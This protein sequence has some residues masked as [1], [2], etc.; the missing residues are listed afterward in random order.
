MTIIQLLEGVL[1][2]AGVVGT[3][4]ATLKYLIRFQRKIDRLL[5]LMALTRNR[6]ED[7]ENFLEKN[8]EFKQKKRIEND[9][10]PEL[11]TDFV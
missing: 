7:V 3:F 11:N 2:I 1:I 10:L 9:E 5:I 4:L 8:T 6:L